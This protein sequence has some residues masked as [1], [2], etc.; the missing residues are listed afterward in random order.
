MEIKNIKKNVLIIRRTH[1][2]LR[3]QKT[4]N[5]ENVL[6][7]IGCSALIGM[8]VTNVKG[9]KMRFRRNVGGDLALL[10]ALDTISDYCEH[11]Y[12]DDCILRILCDKQKKTSPRD[13]CEEVVEKLLDYECKFAQNGMCKW[14]SSNPKSCKYNNVRE[15]MF[16]CIGYCPVGVTKNE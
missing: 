13:W 9:F 12:C 4:A 15:R 6:N 14:S 7:G 1:V 3:N 11:H 10:E 5:L 8:G 16:R 2:P